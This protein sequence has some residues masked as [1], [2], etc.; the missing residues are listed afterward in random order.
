M[1]LYDP[2]AALYSGED[3]LDAVRALS[4][5][6]RRLLREGGMALS[7]PQ[8]AIT[9]PDPEA[10]QGLLQL[11]PRLGRG[12]AAL[13]EDGAKLVEQRR[14]LAHEAARA[15]PLPA[16]LQPVCGCPLRVK[17][18]LREVESTGAVMCTA[19]RCGRHGRGP[20]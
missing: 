3:G 6:A 16:A 8:H 1:R 4:R 18:E 14:P 2:P 10:C 9:S 5:T 12:E 13:E 11:V 7:R 19:S 15:A 20:R 17:V